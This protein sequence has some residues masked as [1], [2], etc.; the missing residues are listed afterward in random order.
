MTAEGALSIRSAGKI[1]DPEGIHVVALENVSFEIGAGEFM[2]LVGP[3]GCGKTTLLN[4]LAGFDELTDGEI[5]MDGDLLASPGRRLVP[6]P[7]RM[8][9]FQ[10]GALFPWKT[11]LWNV[12]CGPIQQ[13]R[14][15]RR[16]AEANARQLMARV[17]LH[18]IEEQFPEALSGGQKRRVEI[19]RALMNEP[20]VL[21]LDEPFRALDAL[22]K[23]VMQEH[24]LELYDYS[25]KTVFFITHDLEEAIFLADRVGVMTTR[26]GRIK[27]LVTIDISRPRDYHVLTT[28]RFLELKA[29]V[30]EAIHEEAKAAFELGE[31]ELA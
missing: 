5:Y 28:N 11:V 31:R 19:V 26:P 29:E 10:Q 6:G 9:V 30:G 8:V 1:Y 2:V 7:D 12:T 27:K 15:T 4:A 24:L 21:L 20:K 3:S 18:G 13:G 16:E 23:S 25:P 17:G 22:T 14:M